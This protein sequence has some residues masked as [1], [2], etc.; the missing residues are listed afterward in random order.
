MKQ[1]PI[2]DSVRLAG[3]MGPLLVAVIAT[4]NPLVNPHLYD[5]QIPPL[6]Y[7]SGTLMFF[8]GFCIVRV[9]NRWRADWTTVV[10]VAGWA[11]MLLG[12][13]RMAFPHAYI[14]NAGGNSLPVIVVEVVLLLL[15]IFLTYKAYFSPTTGDSGE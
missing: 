6:V 1:Q 7:L 12:L 9:H 10:T 5:L 3:L 14:E 11:A 2:T 8:G 13:A 4:E 15:G